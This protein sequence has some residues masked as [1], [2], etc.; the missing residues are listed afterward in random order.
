METTQGND[1]GGANGADNEGGIEQARVSINELKDT[2][3]KARKDHKHITNRIQRFK[4][5]IQQTLSEVQTTT[6]AMFNK[7]MPE[8]VGRKRGFVDIDMGTCFDH[9]I[10]KDFESIGRQF[11]ELGDCSKTLSHLTQKG[12][13][14]KALSHLTQKAVTRHV[15]DGCRIPKF[16]HKLYTMVANEEIDDYISWNRPCCE[17]LIIWDINK[18]ATHVLPMYFKH[19]N[20]SSFNSQLN[21][22]GFKKVSWEKSE[23]ANEWFRRGRYDL[24]GNIKRRSKSLRAITICSTTEVQRFKTRLKTIQQDQENTTLTL[25]SYEKQIKASVDEFKEIVVKL[26][27]VVE[28]MTQK[29]NENTKKSKLETEKNILGDVPGQESEVNEPETTSKEN[30]NV[31]EQSCFQDI[32]ID[33]EVFEKMMM[34]YSS[35]EW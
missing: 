15:G 4:Y 13:C 3:G 32:E 16:L 35:F 34:E 30:G 11:E 6:E 2:L 7:L 33:T 18:F 10:E 1:H 5:D 22:Y 9:D 8:K 21:I 12:D 17:S 24:L 31:K 26:A 23:Y 14:S 20:F 19:S 28:K 27:N 29:S 25:S